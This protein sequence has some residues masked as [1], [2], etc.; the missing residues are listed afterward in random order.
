MT[1]IVSGSYVGPTFI[2][3]YIGPSCMLPVHCRGRIVKVV[4]G[5]GP[6]NGSASRSRTMGGG[7][8]RRRGLKSRGVC[9]SYTIAGNKTSSNQRVSGASSISYIYIY[10]RASY[11]GYSDIMYAV[12]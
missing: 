10:T 2:Y 12:Y 8:A 6:E 11:S 7:V 4:N 1:P 3:I 9:P 5:V